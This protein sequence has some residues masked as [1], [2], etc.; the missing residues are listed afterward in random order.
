MKHFASS[1]PPSASSLRSPLSDRVN[2]RLDAFV[3]TDVL[4]AALYVSSWR[5]YSL[6]AFA[7]ATGGW[8]A[9]GIPRHVPPAAL[10]VTP[11]IPYAV[12]RIHQ[13]VI[14]RSSRERR[15]VFHRHFGAI[16]AL[17]LP[18]LAA[19]GA[20]RWSTIDAA[21]VA[22]LLGLAVGRLGCLRSGCC[23]GRRASIGP[24]YPWLASGHRL[25]PVQLLDAAACLAVVGAALV[26]DAEGARPGTAT[27]VAAGGHLAL[28]F[29]IDELRLERRQSGR[30]EAQW[31]TIAAAFAV[32]A[33]AATVALA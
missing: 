10:V 17:L 27:A 25:L 24:R 19:L 13:R 7:V 28:R 30:T 2:A 18:L 9:L 8:L 22:A 31:L 23:V 32:L 11:V 1:S 16:A 4:I 14:R 21:T 26:C 33:I 3:R 12:L 5:V 29:G 6:A 20:L 15:L